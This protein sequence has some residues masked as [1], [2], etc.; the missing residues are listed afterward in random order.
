MTVSRTA[1]HSVTFCWWPAVNKAVSPCDLN[2]IFVNL[3][4]DH[5]ELVIDTN[6]DD[7]M[8]GFKSNIYIL[9]TICG[10]VYRM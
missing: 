4:S 6:F 8:K 10:K 3:L 9:Q 1:V 7:E 2:T 5:H